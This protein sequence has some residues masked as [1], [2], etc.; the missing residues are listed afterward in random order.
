MLLPSVDRVGRY[1]PLTVVT[2]LPAGAPALT[3]SLAAAPWF[4]EVEA[5]CAQALEDSNLDLDSLDAALA[6]TAGRLAGLD[7]LPAL[8]AF[9]AESAQWH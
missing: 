8:R 6:A 4:G 2:E 7:G 5:L 3:F 1:F 9:P